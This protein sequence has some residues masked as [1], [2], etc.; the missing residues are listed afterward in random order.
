MSR[1]KLQLAVKKA[2]GEPDPDQKGNKRNSVDCF[3]LTITFKF[4]QEPVVLRAVEWEVLERHRRG[5]APAGGPWSR[6]CWQYPDRPDG[7]RG[8][9]AGRPDE[10]QALEHHL[11]RDQVQLALCLRELGGIKRH[12]L[13]LSGAKRGL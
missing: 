12:H 1:R 10:L 2:L 9:F 7:Q 4:E 6:S 8:D 11:D 5:T 3:P 13:R